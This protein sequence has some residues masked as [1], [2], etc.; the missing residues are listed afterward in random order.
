MAKRTKPTSKTA[1][2]IRQVFKWV[3]SD[4]LLPPTKPSKRYAVVDVKG[5]GTTRM[6]EFCDTVGQYKLHLIADKILIAAGFYDRQQ[7]MRQWC[8]EHQDWILAANP[9]AITSDG[10]LSASA[11]FC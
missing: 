5:G 7:E 8:R 10:H 4:E 6:Y 2:K 1:K 11:A 9:N 3:P